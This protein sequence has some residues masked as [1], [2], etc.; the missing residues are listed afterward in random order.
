ML[1]E[2]DLLKDSETHSNI[3]GECDVMHSL[4]LCGNTQSE[5]KIMAEQLDFH[6]KRQAELLEEFKALQSDE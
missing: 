5:F 3:Q 6:Q 4:K 1:T 2:F